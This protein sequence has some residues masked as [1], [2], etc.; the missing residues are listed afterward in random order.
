[1]TVLVRS[2]IAA[3]I[4][5]TLLPPVAF[6]QDTT[7]QQQD[8]KAQCDT[9]TGLARDNCLQKLRAE[10]KLPPDQ[11]KGMNTQRGAPYTPSA[12]PSTSR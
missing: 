5:A 10:G 11:D 9:L 8:P 12:P 3:A 2:A 1:M 7:R 4:I 6:A